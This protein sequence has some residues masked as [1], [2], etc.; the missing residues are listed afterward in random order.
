[1]SGHHPRPGPQPRRATHPAIW[2]AAAAVVALALGA[3]TSSSSPA[4]PAASALATASPGPGSHVHILTGAG[5]TFDYPFF[6][7]AFGRYETEHPTVAIGYSAVG[8]SA[9]IAAFS[10]RQVTFGA[11]DVPMTAAEQAAARGGPVTQVPVDLGGE[12]IVYNLSSRQ[13][14][15]CT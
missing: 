4:N 15:G 11:S 9:G 10:A 6:A 13:A 3:C 7:A 2:A 1:M 12:G 14:P 8:S 5:S